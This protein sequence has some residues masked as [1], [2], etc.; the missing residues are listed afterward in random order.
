M[1][2]AIKRLLQAESQVVFFS[3]LSC[4]PTNHGNILCSFYTP[5]LIKFP[6]PKFKPCEGQSNI[7][8]AY[9]SLF[10]NELFPIFCTKLLEWCF[11]A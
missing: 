3:L 5:Y 8:F 2:F 6:K 10:K 9:E 1:Q 4:P 11:G 7:F